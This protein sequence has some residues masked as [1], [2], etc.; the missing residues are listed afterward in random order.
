MARIDDF[1][2]ELSAQLRRAKDCGASHVEIN[3]GELHRRV[4]GYPGPAPQMPS[5]C[6]AM[7]LAKREGDDVLT[8][9]PP[10]D[11]AALTI[12]YRLP[13]NGAA[14]GPR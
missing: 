5:C 14:K 12:R 7:L 2:A 4:G 9:P 6:R 1:R 3:A 10:E 8:S 13:R 11:G